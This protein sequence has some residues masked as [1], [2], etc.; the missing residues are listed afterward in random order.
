MI[1]ELESD[2]YSDSRHH[3]SDPEHH[4]THHTA[5]RRHLAHRSVQVHRPYR[6]QHQNQEGTS[7][8]PGTSGDHLR[9]NQAAA[10]AMATQIHLFIS[11]LL[12]VRAANE[13]EFVL[14]HPGGGEAGPRRNPQSG[15]HCRSD[16]HSR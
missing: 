3:G 16:P 6:E 8:Q 2:D 5:D 14:L 10:A 1:G 11:E 13:A 15:V 4:Q 12:L 7:G 9:N